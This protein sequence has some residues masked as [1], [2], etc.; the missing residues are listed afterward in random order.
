MNSSSKYI[1][2][3]RR[4][5]ARLPRLAAWLREISAHLNGA[6]F[7]MCITAMTSDGSAPRNLEEA[8]HCGFSGCCM[9]WAALEPSFRKAGLR[10]KP[11]SLVG[12]W[13]PVVAPGADTGST[14]ENV[15]NFFGISC[16]G[17][18]EIFSGGLPD[19]HNPI[20]AAERIER[21]CRDNGI[22]VQQ[23]AGR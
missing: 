11:A 10:L 5:A 6:K 14:F 8:K 22:A 16:R 20:A 19:S 15:A 1:T 7:N 9:G 2:N 18:D 21:F 4:A 12:Q 17:T 3:R 13:N 23:E